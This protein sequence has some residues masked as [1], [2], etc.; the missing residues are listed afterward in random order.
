MYHRQ[1]VSLS[2]GIF[3]P[4]PQIMLC[5]TSSIPLVKDICLFILAY[6]LENITTTL[7]L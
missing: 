7:S 5:I 3:H 6:S 4:L 1:M 2:P